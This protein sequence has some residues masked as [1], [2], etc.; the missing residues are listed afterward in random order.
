MTSLSWLTRPN[1]SFLMSILGLKVT[2]YS[3]KP[4]PSVMTKGT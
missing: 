3:N 4:L 2:S 1:R